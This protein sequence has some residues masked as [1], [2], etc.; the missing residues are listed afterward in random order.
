MTR[1]FSFKLV[2]SE[3]PYIPSHKKFIMLIDLIRQ[4][5]AKLSSLPPK[6]LLTENRKDIEYRV[7]FLRDVINNGIAPQQTLYYQF[8]S[9]DDKGVILDVETVSKNFISLYLNIKKNNI[10]EPIIIG[11]YSSKTV[12]TR[13]IING[14][15]TWK[16]YPNES[17]FQVING[18]HR[19]A[20]ALFL[21]L[22]KIPVKI[23]KTLSFEIPD[24]TEYIRIKEP[25]YRKNLN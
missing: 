4:R 23:Y 24:Y 19:L 3:Q 8:I 12:K 1:I 17:G 20:V 16:N 10:L 6:L 21:D 11:Q 2:Q 5:S 7:E 18:A 9:D 22:E 13:H 25:T 15:K 14:K